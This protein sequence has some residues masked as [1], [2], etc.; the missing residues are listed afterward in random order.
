[1]AAGFGGRA[2]LR[3]QHRGRSAGLK[4]VKELVFARIERADHERR[5]GARGDDD[6][7]ARL[8]EISLCDKTS[9]F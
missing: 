2:L 3:D 7:L 4:F 1:M 5:G 8:R 9:L 6:F